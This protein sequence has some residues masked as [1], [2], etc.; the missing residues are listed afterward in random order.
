MEK[1]IQLENNT[2]AL[3]LFGQRDRN[4][5]KLREDLGIKVVVR[6]DVIRLSGLEKDVLAGYR[7]L[8]DVLANIRNGRSVEEIVIRAPNVDARSPEDPAKAPPKPGHFRF[9][10]LG[11]PVEPRSPGQLDYLKAI[12]KNDVVFCVGPAGTG[13][14]YLAVAMGVSYIRRG[15]F[16]KIVLVRPAVEAGEKLGFLPGDFQAKV[17][18]YLR[19]IYDA[20][21]DFFEVAQLEKYLEREVFEIVPLAFMRG[22]TL[23]DSFIILDEAQNTKVPQMKMFLTRMGVRSKSVITGDVTQIDLGPDVTSGLVH[24]VEALGDVQGISVCHMTR[25]DIV[26]HRL[27]KDIVEAYRLSEAD[28]SR[29]SV[30]GE[31]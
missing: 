25:T 28:E 20:L 30:E 17:N 5:R 3:L 16:R 12:E 26:R 4:L 24:A 23:N 18:P 2:E 29:L 14:T 8:R 1:E 13:K 22:R 10:S 9:P 15:A 19:P 31:V 27:V 6:G 11:E 7:A 21:G